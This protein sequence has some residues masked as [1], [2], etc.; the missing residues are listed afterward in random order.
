MS[1]VLTCLGCA[2]L[3][4]GGSALTVAPAPDNKVEAE[5]VGKLS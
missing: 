3:V 1:K 5:G 4:L 2:V